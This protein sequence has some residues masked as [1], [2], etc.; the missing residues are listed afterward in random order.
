MTE[1]PP[2]ESLKPRGQADER[3][4]DSSI[5]RPREK[6][7]QVTQVNNWEKNHSVEGKRV[8][9]DGCRFTVWKMKGDKSGKE[10]KGP[11]GSQTP[12][13]R[14]ATP[15]DWSPVRQAR[16]QSAPPTPESPPTKKRRLE[17]PDRSPPPGGSGLGP[18]GSGGAGPRGR[19]RKLNQ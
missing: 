12:P 15:M 1:L 5:H 3:Y 4:Q 7:E 14:P 19:K 9:E 11:D 18:A 16:S 8:V 10:G 13:A 17:S 2:G 6:Q